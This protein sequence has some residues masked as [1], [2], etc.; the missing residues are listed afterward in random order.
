MTLGP[1]AE[2]P[3]TVRATWDHWVRT[4][5]RPRLLVLRLLP[6]AG[7]GLLSAAVVVNVVLGLLPVAFVVATSVV[8]GA[9]PEAVAD[10]VG[11]PAWDRLVQVFLLATAAFL[12]Q[13][14]LTP[15]Q[16]VLN[17]RIKRRVDGT[18]LSSVLATTLET[19]SIAPMEDPATLD[20]LD[21]TLTPYQRDFAT[22]GEG[23][24][25]F[26]ALI[27]RYLRLIGFAVLVAVMLAWWAGLALVVATM[28][29]RYGQRGGLRKYSQV[30]QSVVAVRRRSDYLRETAM[31]EGAAKETRIYGLTGWLA[32]RYG[33]SYR[34]MFG[35]VAA[36]RR[37]VY[38]WPFLAITA[39]GLALAV[40]VLVAAARAGAAG[41]I[42]LTALALVLQ[43]VMAAL[44]LGEYFIESDVPTQYGMLSAAARFRLEEHVAQENATAARRAAA[45]VTDRGGQVLTAVPPQTPSRALRFEGVTFT[46]PRT[47]R[48]VL[49]GLD[50]ELVAGRSTAVVGVNGA[51]KTT[52]VK[53]LTRLH[54][55]DEGRIT[56][57]GLDLAVIEPSAW[58]RQVSVIFQDFVR[59]EFSAADNIALGAT[60]RPRDDDA[61]H[62]AAERAGILEAFDHLPLGLDAPLARAYDGGVDLSGGQWQRIAIARSLYALDAGAKVLVL[63][64][65]TS[66]LDVR[67]EAAF[68]DRFVELTRGVTSL[69]ISHRFSSVRRADHVVVVDGGSVTEQG[70]HDELMAA[71]GHYARLFRLQAERFSA[72]MDAEGNPVGHASGTALEE[73]SR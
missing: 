46:Y 31:G 66:A 34:T 20:L 6:E 22:P 38:L 72:G 36:R 4:A 68:F 13:Q 50:L 62:A 18:V 65:P 26:L 17:I 3:A 21:E 24:G 10:G 40:V 61:V 14:A 57:D 25:G 7:A 37:Q 1:S 54:D 56:A 12:A 43:S 27:A 42:D 67:A 45:L 2:H 70:S 28:L 64:E 55:P 58:R 47:T 44:L 59:Y 23:V 8:V 49:D 29:F 69:L 15:V 5:V 63:D 60:H 33:E 19:A 52:L 51:G 73:G 9:V 71:D 16:G 48:P 39:V 32:D 41:A 11:S 53:L 35:A 30:W